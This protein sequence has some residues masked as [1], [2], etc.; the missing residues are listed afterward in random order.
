M[1]RICGINLSHNGSFAIVEDGEVVF[2]LEEERLSKIKRDR[3]AIQVVKKYLDSTI[4]KVTI[5]DCYTRYY[6][7]KFILRLKQKS[8]LTRIVKDLGIP[9]IDYRNRHHECHAA[10]AFYNSGFDDAVCVVMDGKGSAVVKDELNFCEVESIF[11]HDDDGFIPIFKHFSTFWSEEECAKLKEPYWDGSYFYSDRTS[12]GQAYRRVS[13]FC[14]FDEREA[15][16]TM[17]LAPYCETKQEPNLFNVEYDHSV[18]SKELYAEGHTTGY[19]G[20]ECTKIELAHRLQISA[21][22]HALRIIRKAV[23]MTGKT[24]VVVSGGFFLNCV[25]NYKIMKELDINLYV[26]PLSYDGGLSIGS[27]LLEHYEDT[28][29]GTRLYPEPYQGG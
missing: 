16:K 19:S 12:V 1:A 5:C 2:Y 28:L 20:P 11:V 3:S 29:F 13:R 24:N 6:P 21:E 25:A 8:N 10:N 23:M 7:E 15:G 18:C 14:G 27:A 26:D 4:D 9:I 17:G 22:Q